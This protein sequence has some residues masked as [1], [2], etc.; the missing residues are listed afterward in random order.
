MEFENVVLVVADTL[1]AKNLPSYNS[2]KDT[3]EFLRDQKSV[4]NYYS[5]SPWTV[6]AHATLFT[7]QLPS[8]HGTTTKNT[9][10]DSENKLVSKFREN[11]Y[12][13]IG[14]TENGLVSPH[15]GFGSEF[16]VFGKSNWFMAGA[17]SWNAI[18]KRDSQYKDRKDKYSD[19]LRLLAKNRD[20]KSIEAA[21]K[22]LYSQ[23]ED[24]NPTKSKNTINNGLKA[25]NE[26]KDTFL[27]LN[28]M[29]VHAPYTFTKRQKDRYLSDLNDKEIEQ[30][31]G[32]ERLIDYLE[33]GV[34]I[35][36]LF[37]KREKAYD[38]SISYFDT[39]IQILFEKAPQDTLFVVIGDHGELIGEY[40]LGGTRLVN[41]HFGTFKELIEVPLYIFSK[42]Q[43]VD[44]DAAGIYD[45]RSLHEF[46]LNVAENQTLDLPEKELVRSEYF[47]K[48]GFNKQFDSNMPEEYKE[49]FERKSFSLV[50]SRYKYDITSDGNYLWSSGALSEKE[51]LEGVEVP[52][53]LLNKADVL[54]NWRLE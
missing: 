16:D 22:Y 1:R 45:H 32:F 27:F 19:F 10:F 5:N 7:G 48:I 9:Y 44:I 6:P 35:E 33:A 28:L 47:G 13:T 53:K 39:L 3:T 26:E 43:E 40:E 34:D 17:D 12:Y 11:G 20:L 38:A 21:F 31:T 2:D 24:Y 41:H 36:K 25:L 51:M 52:E 4:S 54:Y 15:L 49:L 37:E 18:W 42:G 23:G 29:P 8:E 14:I 30:I 50:N 46:L